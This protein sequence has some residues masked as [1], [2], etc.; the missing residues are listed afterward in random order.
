MSLISTRNL[1]IFRWFKIFFEFRPIWAIAVVYYVHI[2]GS[3]GLAMS[4]CTVVT[5]SAAALEIPTGVVSDFLGRRKTFIAGAAAT[6]VAYMLFAVAHSYW[7]LAVA[8]LLEGLSAALFSGNND[9]LLYE[10][11]KQDGQEAHYAEHKGKLG[12][13]GSFAAAAGALVSG[14]IA[15]IAF[16][17]V[18]WASLVTA[19][20]ALGCAFFFVEPA[21][22]GRS[23]NETFFSHLRE[24]VMQ[25][26]HNAKLRNL[27]IASTLDWGLGG[28]ANVFQVAFVATLW[29]TWA[30]GFAQ[31]ARDLSYAV[32]GW[33]SGR[34]LKFF[35]SER[36]LFGV[37]FARSAIGLVAYGFP[38]VAS[39]AILAV[40]DALVAPAHAAQ[41]ELMQK[42]FTE[43]QRATIDSLNSLMG[44]LFMGICSIGL[45]FLADYIGV[46]HSL[47][48]TQILLLPIL[49][50]YFLV[51]K[52]KR[53]R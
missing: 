24:A 15:S 32:A 6:C 35:G 16:V 47:V 51:L 10:S 43:H 5:V 33:F 1:T 50:V 27:S 2:T 13:I 41:S 45:G 36:W 26:K 7:P 44:N 38:T 25:F 29:P 49:Y 30:I 52:H 12:S 42:E 4:L 9:A 3:Y 53:L 14:F 39:P 23:E 37:S 8:A 18:A 28:S 48:V 20:L 17:Y 40:D 19:L 11:L 22:R 21:R 34:V 46:A 31:V